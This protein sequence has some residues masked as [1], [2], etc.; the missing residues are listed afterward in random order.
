MQPLL[1]SKAEESPSGQHMQ[2]PTIS[3]DATL[4]PPR[5]ETKE[6]HANKL[7]NYFARKATG[8]S[9][10]E[11]E[12]VDIPDVATHVRTT[13]LRLHQ[14]RHTYAEDKNFQIVKDAL[15]ELRGYVNE[16]RLR[17]ITTD[18]PKTHKTIRRYFKERSFRTIRFDQPKSPAEATGAL[19]GKAARHYVSHSHMWGTYYVKVLVL[20]Q[21][22]QW[23]SATPFSRCASYTKDELPAG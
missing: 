12:A 13:Y 1:Q 23:L 5:K 21:V 15:S 2:Q 8:N 22:R 14:K 19:E 18:P 10:P 3:A 9:P 7:D 4:H 16:K 11:I 6:A 20:A 17:K